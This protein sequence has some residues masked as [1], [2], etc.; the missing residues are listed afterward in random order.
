[1]NHL[2][3]SG[4]S[5]K[6]DVRK[7]NERWPALKEGDKISYAAL[8]T[9]IGVDRHQARFKTV[10]GAWRKH[11]DQN[12]IILYPVYN[13]GYGVA[14]PH[15]RANIVVG[16]EKSGVKKIAKAS[17]I[18]ARTDKTALTA[19]ESAYVNHSIMFRERVL[20]LRQADQ[21]ELRLELK[22]YKSVSK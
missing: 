16:M 18:A 7:L 20:A 19:Q 9:V 22:S 13:E 11:L 8:E 17:S 14:D 1:M 4:L 3:V 5:T 12:N 10:F 21:K 6:D 15:Q 2:R